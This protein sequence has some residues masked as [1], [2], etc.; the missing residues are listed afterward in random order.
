M[1][2]ASYKTQQYRFFVFTSPLPAP[3]LPLPS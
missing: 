3:Y 2:S 1:Q